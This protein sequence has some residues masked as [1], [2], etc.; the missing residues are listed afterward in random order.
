MS[1]ATDQL[2]NYNGTATNV[3]FNTEGKFGF[4][5]AFNGGASYLNLNSA[6]LP[7]SVFSV[8]MWINLNSL[9]TGWLFSQYTGGVT[10]RFIF[11][12]TSTGGFQINVSSTNSL[13][14]T[15]IPVITTNNWHHVVV[16]KDGSNGWILYADGASLSTWNS[17]ENIITNQ[18]TILGGD[19]SVTSSNM[20]GK[21]DQIRI[22]DSAI[23]A[24][25][26]TT[27]YEEIECPAVAV[28]N[29]FNTV[30]YTGNGSTQSVT[31]TGFKPDL[32]WVKNR[33]TAGNNHN[34]ADSIRGVNNVIQSN[35]TAAQYFNS[36]YQFNSFDTDGITVTDDAAGN[37]GFNGNNETY[38]SWNW[39]A[40]GAAVSNTDGTI[41]SQV[42]ANVD[43][44]FS[45]LK[46][47]GNGSTAQ[48]SYGHGL[49][50]A[51]ELL[52]TK[53][54]DTATQGTNSW[55]VGGTLLGNGGYMFLNGA[56]AKSTAS[57][58]NGNKVPDSEVIYTSGTSDLVGNQNG[59]NF[60]T[61][62]FHSV[63]GYSKF[64]SYDGD[65]SNPTFIYTGF[66]PAFV[67]IKATNVAQS[68]YMFD[69]KR[70]NTSGAASPAILFAN[71]SAAEYTTNNSDLYMTFSDNGFQPATAISGMNGTG[72]SF[73][74]MA[75]A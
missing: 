45:I 26:V 30:I 7:A 4:A 64:G 35:L 1:D 29:A 73:I 50:S 52:M 19:D 67:M 34:L 13:S 20:V 46:Y 43:A 53:N 74:Y 25:N 27:L 42:S 31:G 56:N 49:S 59:I 28:T 44:G 40:G 9:S 22:Y 15:N 3:N 54:I 8:S 69:N 57:S 38:V 66:R 33:N 23:S 41:T 70:G 10:G 2:G 65:T 51:P 6:V 39:K 32:S 24:E 71:D 21:I 37:W 75:I 55:V 63:D 18:N 17:T 5:G 14:T 72:R 68:W 61:Y 60:I 36:T 48:Q 16:V 12:V 62:A 47:T 11:N 58:Y